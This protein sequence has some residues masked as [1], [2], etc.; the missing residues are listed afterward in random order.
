MPH[1]TLNDLRRTF[2]T[3]QA[4][5][6]VAPEDLVHF[7]GHVDDT[8]LRKIYPRKAPACIVWMGPLRQAMFTS[9]FAKIRLGWFFSVSPRTL[10]RESGRSR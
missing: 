4:R 2:A 1:V 6:G 10:P 8:M 5:G 3:L 7:M 9:A